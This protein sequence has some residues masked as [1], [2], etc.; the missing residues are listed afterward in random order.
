MTYTPKVGDQV[1]LPEWP[2]NDAVL[3]LAISDDQMWAKNSDGTRRTLLLVP[4]GTPWVKVEP[5]PVLPAAPDQW[6]AIYTNFTGGAC[7]KTAADALDHG[8]IIAARRYTATDD[9]VWRD[10]VES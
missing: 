10:E 7:W 4:P 8:S 3:V 9:V 2:N 1:K 5:R 6:A